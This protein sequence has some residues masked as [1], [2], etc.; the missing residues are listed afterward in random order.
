MGAVLSVL[1]YYGVTQRLAVSTAWS[2]QTVMG[3]TAA[4]TLAVT[5]NIFMNSVSSN[6]VLFSV[7]VCK[8]TV[9]VWILIYHQFG[10]CVLPE[11]DIHYQRHHEHDQEPI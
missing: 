8:Y 2:L 7:F 1:Y 10:L 6:A 9:A 5:S 4:E 11:K 3:T